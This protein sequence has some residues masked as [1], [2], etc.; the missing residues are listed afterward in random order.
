MGDAEHE[1]DVQ[2]IRFLNLGEILGNKLFKTN[3]A[4]NKV[5]LKYYFVF[6]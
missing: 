4:L 1:T 5:I 6:R 2:R 3:K